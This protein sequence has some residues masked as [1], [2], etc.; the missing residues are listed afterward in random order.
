MIIRYRSNYY[1]IFK[2]KME[3][4]QITSLSRITLENPR[5]L[6]M[7]TQIKFRNINT[8]GSGGILI[9]NPSFKNPYGNF[10]FGSNN[11][12]FSLE[13]RTI[14]LSDPMFFQ[15]GIPIEI[16]PTGAT[17]SFTIDLEFVELQLL[18]SEE[19]IE[20]IE[21]QPTQLI[22]TDEI[23]YNTQQQEYNLQYLGSIYHEISLTKNNNSLSI[24]L[25]MDKDF[26]I[27]KGYEL[28]NS[29]SSLQPGLSVNIETYPSI[30][31]KQEEWGSTLRLND[32]ELTLS[33]PDFFKTNIGGGLSQGGIYPPAYPSIADVEN[34]IN[35]TKLMPRIIP[36]G[37]N[38]SIF[39]HDQNLVALTDYSISIALEIAFYKKI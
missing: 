1:E 8:S 35:S 13:N 39:S 38:I 18:N 29:S 5:Y 9:N 22:W 32:T 21:D 7:L 14:I 19:A 12:V 28:Y 26:A 20:I 25:P 36:R 16:Q 31:S 2:H 15:I 11:G 27:I 17:P 6:K 24:Q 37:T 34:F 23:T 33:P 3:S 4:F 30:N 10:A